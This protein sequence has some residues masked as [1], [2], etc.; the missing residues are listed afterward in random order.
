MEL[1]QQS[2]RGGGL[3]DALKQYGV[4]RS[5]SITQQAGIQIEEK[6][7]RILEKRFDEEKQKSMHLDDRL[8]SLKDLIDEKSEMAGH[9]SRD[10]DSG[11]QMAMYLEMHS[12]NNRDIPDEF[13]DMAEREAASRRKIDRTVS[14]MNKIVQ[15]KEAKS[16]AALKELL[17]RDGSKLKAYLDRASCLVQMIREL[18]A[19]QASG[20]D[21]SSIEQELHGA[22]TKRTQEEESLFEEA[23]A[24]LEGLALSLKAPA[25]T[26]ATPL[27]CGT[28]E[29][30]GP[31]DAASSADDISS[32]P[33]SP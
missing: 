23:D 27:R 29:V 30:V 10:I 12:M 9:L 19:A 1:V 5:H 11:N 18:Q 4:L 25:A 32:A 6:K 21:T 33:P 22:L 28:K 31:T 15:T 13:E 2:A 26:P 7:L 3:A 24:E 20:G 17:E 14:T 8:R 16:R